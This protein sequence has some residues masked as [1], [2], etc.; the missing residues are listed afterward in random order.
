MTDWLL[1]LVN[2]VTRE[3]AAHILLLFWRAWHL[4]ND[5]VHGW[6]IGYVMGLT[7]FLTSYSDSLQ[8]VSRALQTGA[9]DKSKAKVG[10]VTRPGKMDKGGTNG[11]TQL[12][13]AGNHHHLGGSR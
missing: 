6:C 11:V 2:L 7:N 4:R 12:Q 13:K 5:M 8:I 3:T 1:L 10:E 9:N